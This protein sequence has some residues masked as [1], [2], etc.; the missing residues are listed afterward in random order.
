MKWKKIIRETGLREWVCEHG[1]G[2]PDELSANIIAA[3]M[4]YCAGVELDRNG[5]TTFADGE[6][7]IKG[8][9]TFKDLVKTW[10]IHGCDGCCQ[11]DNFPGKILKNLH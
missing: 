11:R 4:V 5:K 9:I 10:M 3:E 2:H 6:S 8:E 7:V 1:I